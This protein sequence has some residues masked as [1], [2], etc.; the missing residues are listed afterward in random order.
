MRGSVSVARWIGTSMTLAMAGCVA[1]CSHRTVAASPDVSVSAADAATRVA[2]RRRRGRR[3][4][5]TNYAARASTGPS[6]AMAAHAPSDRGL[7][8]PGAATNDD[9]ALGD[10]PGDDEEPAPAARPRITETG[11]MLSENVG[12][13]GNVNYDMTGSTAGG[14]MG[15]DASQISQGLRPLMGRFTNCAAATGAHG[16]VAVRL[17]IQNS[18]APVAAR[19]T[20]PGG[21][22]FITCVRRVVA[23]AR[24]DRFNG[25]D[26]FATWGFDVD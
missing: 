16:H 25:P 7:A 2:G 5:R 24:F 17:R 23:S 22:E 9:L 12:S 8:D 19:V 18:G 26:A 14:P 6:G 1:A 13:P 21:G 11:P 3:G 20:G 4:S 15:L 10:D